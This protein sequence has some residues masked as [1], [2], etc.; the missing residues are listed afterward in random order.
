MPS[1][2]HAW[3]R[4]HLDDSYGKY[5]ETVAMAMP[6]WT[7]RP[8]GHLAVSPASPR[9]LALVSRR[10]QGSSSS[11]PGR[12][13]RAAMYAASHRVPP[14]APGRVLVSSVLRRRPVSASPSRSSFCGARYRADGPADYRACTDAVARRAKY[15]RCCGQCRLV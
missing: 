6:E 12:A 2:G 4:L 9:L 7:S 13:R 5:R 10:R 11:R 3:R 14:A 15:W 1:R 8:E